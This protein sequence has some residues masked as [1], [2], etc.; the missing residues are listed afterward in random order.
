ML[1]NTF[2]HLLKPSHIQCQKCTLESY[3][4]FAIYFVLKLSIIEMMSKSTTKAKIW[5]RKK[6]REN[7]WHA[8]HRTMQRIYKIP[9]HMNS[10]SRHKPDLL[11]AIYNGLS[12]LFVW[13]FLPRNISKPQ[14]PCYHTKN[15]QKWLFL[16]IM[17][18]RN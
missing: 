16:Q 7:L 3:T 6:N 14:Q 13:V 12:F 9:R 11:T 15:L 8:M 2:T 4:K 5:C 1:L 17:K 18:I 10:F